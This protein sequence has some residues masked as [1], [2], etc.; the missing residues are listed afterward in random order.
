MGIDKISANFIK[1]SVHIFALFL[2]G[3]VYNL[4][5][6]RTFPS[7]WNLALR[8]PLHKVN[9]KIINSDFRPIS[10]LPAFSKI[11]K[12]CWANKRNIISTKTNSEINFNRLI[13]KI[14][15][16]QQFY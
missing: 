6:Y 3:I 1:L 13:P 9:H 14:V 7:R 2:T 10:L 8:K 11:L 4:I 5:K 15:V 12:K 16:A